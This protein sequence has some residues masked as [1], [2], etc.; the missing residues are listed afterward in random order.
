[1]SK[2]NEFEIISSQ[3][4][5]YSYWAISREVSHSYFKAFLLLNKINFIFIINSKFP[6]SIIKTDYMTLKI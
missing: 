2:M 1:M 5:K 3:I 4:I 6:L